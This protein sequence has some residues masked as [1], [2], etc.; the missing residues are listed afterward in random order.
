MEEG[1]VRGLPAAKLIAIG[2]SLPPRKPFISRE[3][4]IAL[5]EERY[6]YP[7]QPGQSKRSVSFRVKAL[8]WQLERFA[9]MC[10]LEPQ[11]AASVMNCHELQF[12]WALMLFRYKWRIY[13]G[14]AG[15][16][17]HAVDTFIKSQIDQAE[18]VRR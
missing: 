14:P 7:G 16:L 17:L 9:E 10:I 15:S 13:R 12:H 5:L 2:E 18:D 3:R 4:M 1:F 8:E 11:F 6:G